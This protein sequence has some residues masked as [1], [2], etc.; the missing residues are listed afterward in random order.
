VREA[1]DGEHPVTKAAH[2][3]SRLAR[4]TNRMTAAFR[5]FG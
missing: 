2:A 1:L 5:N 3:V 4:D